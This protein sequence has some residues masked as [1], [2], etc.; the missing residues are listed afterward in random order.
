[1][2]FCIMI[3]LEAYGG[4]RVKCGGLDKNVTHIHIFECSHQGV[5][6][7]E[8]GEDWCGFVEIGV[9]L[10]EELCHWGQA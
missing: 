4:W 1:M 8:K 2:H 7:Y 5:V 6:P 9:A 3:W 10:L